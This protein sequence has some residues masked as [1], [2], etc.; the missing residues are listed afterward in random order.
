MREMSVNTTPMPGVPPSARAPSLPQGTSAHH[1]PIV[2]A[3]IG[4]RWAK[5]QASRFGWLSCNLV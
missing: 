1:T 4:Q 5:D 3:R 2:Q